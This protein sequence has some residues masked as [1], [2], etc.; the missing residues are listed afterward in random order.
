MPTARRFTIKYGTEPYCDLVQQLWSSGH[1]IALHTRDHIYLY[2]PIDANK[3][4]ELMFNI[5]QLVAW[6]L[7]LS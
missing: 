4:C 6:L 1:E 7:V 2:P 3:T 5:W